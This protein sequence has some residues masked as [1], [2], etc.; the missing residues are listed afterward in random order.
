MNVVNLLN[1]PDRTFNKTLKT[2]S[3]ILITVFVSI[4]VF[5]FRDDYWK[6]VIL[7]A[8]TI[9]ITD[10]YIGTKTE[11]LVD[12]NKETM[13]KLNEIQKKMYEYVDLD[14]KTKKV[15][16]SPSDLNKIYESAKMT[17]L[18]IDAE[19]VSFIHSILAMYDYS[20]SEFY[21]MVNGTNVILGM[22]SDIR[23]FYKANKAYPNNT[24]DM[25]K[26]ALEIK[27]NCLNNIHNFIYSIPKQKE[28][29]K[30]HSNVMNRYD[31]LLT[32]IVNEIHKHDS[33]NI[34]L[35]GVNSSTKFSDYNPK[36]KTPA[37]NDTSRDNKFFI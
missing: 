34:Q 36:Y 10:V 19:L 4:L 17:S 23:R 24:S 11:S 31:K 37:R 5:T 25:L 9:I 15:I 7:L 27:S 22:L 18:Y 6:I 13:K 20:P 30:Y 16:P 14:L 1:S 32:R 3:L 26:R 28:F 21:K 35:T 29:F 8:A 2:Q 12:D 33:R